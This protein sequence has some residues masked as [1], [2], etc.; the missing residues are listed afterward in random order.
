MAIPTN[1]FGTERGGWLH[2]GDC[3]ANEPSAWSRM[4]TTRIWKRY[5]I[6]IA[7]CH[8]LI[9]SSNECEQVFRRTTIMSSGLA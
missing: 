5:N 6:G 3:T 2:D 8:Q 1:S 9:C 7:V 4:P